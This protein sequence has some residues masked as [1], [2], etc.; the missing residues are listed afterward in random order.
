LA[1]EPHFLPSYAF[2]QD[3]AKLL[4]RQ[5]KLSDDLRLER[6]LEYGIAEYAPGSEVI[7]DGRLLTSGIDLQNR[8]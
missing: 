3:V 5:D 2:P 6:D 8:N 4:V 1:S 7:A